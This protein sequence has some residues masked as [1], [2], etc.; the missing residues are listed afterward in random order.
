MSTHP[1]HIVDDHN[2]LSPSAFIPFCSLAGNLSIL[3]QVVPSFS[4]PVCT[5]FKPTIVRDKLCYKVDLNQVNDKVDMKELMTHGLSFLM[6]YNEDRQA[7]SKPSYSGSEQ[8][9][10][11]TYSK[12]DKQEAMIYIETIGMDASIH[13]NNQNNLY[14]RW[15]SIKI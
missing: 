7:Q 15:N 10:W 5:A 8:A 4:I 6:D 3:G 1:P 2:N 11:D 14:G 9:L 12:I 13:H